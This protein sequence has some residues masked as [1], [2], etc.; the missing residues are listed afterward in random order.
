ML[1]ELSINR[2]LFLVTSK[3]TAIAEQMLPPIRCGTISMK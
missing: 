1:A 2:R 3:N